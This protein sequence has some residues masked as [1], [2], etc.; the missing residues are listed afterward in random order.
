MA[1]NSLSA[2]SKTNPGSSFRLT[3][4]SSPILRPSTRS[5]MHKA[6][7]QQAVLSL[8]TVIGTTTNSPN[9]F[10]SHAGSNSF[11]ICAGS[12]VVLAELDEQNTLQ[13]RFFRA[14]P[15][16]T[17]VNPVTSYYNTS[18]PPTTPDG[19][20][21]TPSGPKSAAQSIVHNGTP[22][23]ELV[24]S[25]SSRGWS[26]RE[27]VKAVTSVAI[28]SHGGL[29]AVGETGYGPRVL[30]YSTAKGASCDVPLS[31]LT[32]HT[33]G[34][35]ALSFSPDSQYLATLGDV[36][37]GFLFV[38][39]VNPKTGLARLHST[40]KCTSFIR[41]MAWVGQTLVTVGI[42]HVKVWRLPDVRPGS[43]KS[44]LIADSCASSS[45]HTPKALSG[46]NCLLGSL[47]E[48]TF[49]SVIS[50]SDCESVVGTDTGALCFLDHNEGAQKLSVAHYFDYAISSLA[51]D[52][53][54]SC[55]W[56]GGRGGR[57]QCM[58]LEKLRSLIVPSSPASSGRSSVELSSKGP[59]ITC[60]G[61]LGP[62]LVAV[63]ASNTIN[64]FS[65]DEL[66]VDVDVNSTELGNTLSA[67]KDAVLGIS[68]LS[69]PNLLEAEF[70][71]WSRNGIVKF[72]DG[73][74][75]CRDSRSIVLEHSSGVNEDTPNELKVL[76]AIENMDY[77]VSGDRCGVLRLWQNQPWKCI[78]EVRAHAG[79]ITDIAMHFTSQG[80]L[81]ASSSR[82]RTVQLFVWA[83]D[84]LDLIQTMDDHVGAVSHIIFIDDGKRLLS[85]SADRTIQIRESVSREAHGTSMFAYL[86]SKVI[87]LKA[88]P[89]SMALLPG[90]EN[91]LIVSTTDRYIQRIDL[92]S[93]RQTHCFR[94][95]DADSAD[96]VV[97][98]SLTVSAETLG[99]DSPRML[100]G[101]SASDK[102]IRVYDLDRGV[103]LAAEFGHTEGVSDVCLLSRSSNSTS[104]MKEFSLVSSGNDGL[105]MLWDLSLLTQGSRD[106]V[107]LGNSEEDDS[108]AKTST[109]ARPPLRKVL[110]RSDIAGFQRQENVAITPT[111]ARGHSP[112][113]LRKFAKLTLSPSMRSGSLSPTTPSATPSRQSPTSSTHRDKGHASPSL[114]KQKPPSA[115]KAVCSRK[116]SRRSSMDFRARARSMGKSDLGTLDTSTEQVCRTLKAYRKKLNNSTDY[117]HAHKDL[118]RELE[119]TLRALR[120]RN[121]ASGT[122]ENDTDSSG[123]ENQKTSS[124]GELHGDSY[125]TGPL[126]SMP[127]IRR[128]ESSAPSEISSLVLNGED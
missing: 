40:N 120:S 6:P 103:L 81:I 17:S 13:Q 82:D 111:P 122:L 42:R 31:I 51:V 43:P 79:E 37:D 69:T 64:I 102:S 112:T 23:S 3:P 76:H 121:P 49:T 58:S 18:T 93:G 27:R 2:K 105:V 113:F 128:T 116:E 68:P 118:E 75:K 63:D 41:D 14:R 110:S 7:T 127:E 88:S 78:Q 66:G 39:A 77:F 123:K 106:S 24:D 5:S 47:A 10:S 94:A 67:H 48:S 35:R 38:W 21:K 99:H 84:S 108:P 85:C 25:N 55:L 30:I 125:G 32:E 95:T 52:M 9:G 62:N 8:Q 60:M 124:V 119:L 92:S 109:V 117:F 11:A 1:Y 16:V 101:V 126:Q 22:N 100:V 71:T 26:S 104:Q 44:R 46:R 12:T 36:N 83:N 89:V 90:N 80:L 4:T 29:L 33:F 74:G 70:Y 56:V 115:K 98:N 96:T 61:C 86:V 87:T 97:L 45:N 57:I 53:D 50:I 72:W 28:S 114:C 19:R 15:S 54:N 73:R 34:V 20:A 107:H 59:T 65:I 91:T